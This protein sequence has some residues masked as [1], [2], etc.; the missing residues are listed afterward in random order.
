MITIT[1]WVFVVLQQQANRA[2]TSALQTKVEDIGDNYRKRLQHCL[3]ALRSCT[4]LLLGSEQVTTAEWKSFTHSL[5]IA[6]RYPGILG[7]GYCDYVRREE[8]SAYTSAARADGYP[9]YT[10]HPASSAP[11]FAPVRFLEPQD[12]NK[13]VIG[14]DGL[15]EKIRREAF[16]SSRDSGNEII[17][18]PIKLIQDE[19]NRV[20]YLLLVPI[21]LSDDILTTVEQRRAS[22]R[23]WVYAPIIP[24]T[25]LAHID[26]Y[27]QDFLLSV[28]DATENHVAISTSLKKTDTQKVTSIITFAE[29]EWEF[30]LQ[31]HAT[32]A[33]P[34]YT[35]PWMALFVGFI[36]CAFFLTLLTLLHKQRVLAENTARSRGNELAK[37]E[38]RWQTAHETFN[39]GIW[40]YDFITKKLHVTQRWITLL[41]ISQEE[42]DYASEYWYNYIHPDDQAKLQ[43]LWL[44]LY[45]K[46][47]E[48]MVCDLRLR[49]KDNSYLIVNFRGRIQYDAEGNKIC[50]IGSHTDIT[51]QKLAEEKLHASETGY[52]NTV[53]NLPV[54]VFHLDQDS[55]WTFLNQAWSTLTGVPIEESLST[56]FT[57]QIHP[58]DRATAAQW[59]TDL[60][61]GKVTK[62]IGELRFLKR[63]RTFRWVD[64]SAHILPSD[65]NQIV[66]SLTDITRRKMA[67]LS[68]HASEEKLRSLFERSP[69]G[70]ALSRFD[71]SFLLVNTAFIQITGRTAEECTQLS[72]THL[73]PQEALSLENEC[74]NALNKE[75][76]FGP[77]DTTY[78]Q[79]D[80][81]LIPVRVNGL[82]IRDINGTQ[83]IWRFVENSTLHIAAEDALRQARDVAESANRAKS[84]FLATMSHEIRTPMNGILGMTRLLSNS[85]LSKEQNEYVE[86]VRS[87]AESLLSL[88]NDILDLSKIEAGRMELEAIPFAIRNTIDDSVALL[89]SRI[90]EQE[91][92]CMVDC[93]PDVPTRIMG[94]PVRLRQVLLNILSNAVKFTKHGEIIITASKVSEKYYQISISDTGIGI[95]PTIQQGLFQAFAQGD[96]ST[97]RIHGGSGL[98]LAICRQLISLMGGTITL[99]SKEG[100]GS[101][102]TIV[103]PLAESAADSSI[104][105]TLHQRGLYLFHTSEAICRC[106]THLAQFHNIPFHVCD[107]SQSAAAKFSPQSVIMLDGDNSEAKSLY[108][109][110]KQQRLTIMVLT[111]HLSQWQEFHD[112]HVIAKPLR[113]ARFYQNYLKVTGLT[114]DVPQTT[115]DINAPITPRDENVLIIDDNIIN[116]RVVAAMLKRLGYM[117]DIADNGQAGLDKL[118]E[119]IQKNQPYLFVLMDCQMPIMDGFTTTR[120]WREREKS[121][122]TYQH[123]PIVALTANVFSSDRDSCLAAGMDDFLSKPLLFENLIAIIE[124]VELLANKAE[125]QSIISDPQST[126]SA[127]DVQM[128]DPAP[129]QHLLAGTGDVTIIREVAGIFKNDAMEQLQVI[130][131]LYEQ[132]DYIHLARAAHKFKGACLTV[133]LLQCASICE[134]LDQKAHAADSNAITIL[135]SQ[136]RSCFPTALETLEKAV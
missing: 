77:F 87:S 35:Q 7:L 72:H 56:P 49:K 2:T 38:A 50:F 73:L 57:D 91:L 46:E 126:T 52:R 124:R 6:D 12:N 47:T 105:M 55:N 129:L 62:V 133:G 114:S 9:N 65:P 106:F 109:L 136:L 14:Y 42:I 67:D 134:L 48:K 37:S 125:I 119:S 3:D 85:P 63:L 71:G 8:V 79:K 28:Y 100:H 118:E 82:I 117:S 99:D 33:I 75:G 16:F 18:G 89:A 20:G 127:Q 61:S 128:F 95:A 90:N 83:L 53:D 40:E 84:A 103:L 13:G 64:F 76:R 107:L 111:R 4:G 59:F 93:H 60:K 92:E 31:P 27:N 96:N 101:T 110:L 131:K 26:M 39:D 54:V 41:G 123:L 29:R 36:L 122:N 70:I 81:T 43:L 98:G 135:I 22:L 80:G 68:I 15:T 45:N 44:Q 120:L 115:Y 58:D 1:A 30:H 121:Q 88:L 17:T 74:I 94:D 21:Y 5:H 23:G 66:G 19:K 102:F 104:N 130:L 112:I 97:T 24:E 34:T 132:K 25:L 78:R 113:I 86:I 32:W 10:I 51:A 69:I 11:F 108:H 116:S